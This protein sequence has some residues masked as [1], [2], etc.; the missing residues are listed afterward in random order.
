MFPIPQDP[1]SHLS[2][3][4]GTGLWVDPITGSQNAK[5]FLEFYFSM[6]PFSVSVSQ[7]P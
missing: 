5:F 1:A 6:K 3:D 4:D 2:E 7:D